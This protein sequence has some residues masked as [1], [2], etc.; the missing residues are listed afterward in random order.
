MAKFHPYLPPLRRRIISRFLIIVG[1]YAIFGIVMI[2][3]VFFASRMTPRLIHV[4]YD[5]IAAANQMNESWFNINSPQTDP[6]GNLDLWQAN[7]ETALNIEEHNI[8]EPGEGDVAKNIRTLWD[9]SKS[10]LTSI[11]QGDFLKMKNLLHRL[12]SI[13]E[14]GMFRIA[15]DSA[16]LSH[17]VFMGGIV[18]LVV[19]LIFVFFVSNGIANRLAYPLKAMAETLRSRPALGTKLKLPNPT[20]LELKILNHEMMQLWNNLSDLRQLNVEEINVQRNQLR[21]ILTF[22]EDA[23]LVLNIDGTVLHANPGL[24]KYLNLPLE[25]IIGRQWNDLSTSNENYLHLRAVLQSDLGQHHATQIVVNGQNRSLSIRFREIENEKKQVT[26]ILYLLHDV[27]ERRQTEKLRRE[28]I[29]VLSHEL[30]TPLQSLSVCSQLLNEH[31]GVLS[32]DGQ[33]LV[34]TINEDV[35]RIRAVANDFIQVGVENLSSLKLM[36]EQVHLEDVIPQWLKPFKVLAKDKKINIEFETK[37]S[38]K[39]LAKIDQVKFPWVISNIL[40][41]SIRI[42]P[43]NTKIRV[44]LKQS[45]DEIFVEIADEGPGIPPEVQK[46]MFDPY[47]QASEPGDGKATGFLGIGLT[48]AKEVVEAHNGSIKFTPNVPHGA[49]FTV[50]LPRIHL[51]G[52]LA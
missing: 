41:N 3:A 24:Q 9:S 8:T 11:P 43:P 35:S 19:T 44:I 16:T 17:E 4:N 48:I 32:N 1:L 27:T 22:V 31:K 26:G 33:L 23:I 39:S 28:F 2:A 7:F 36:L 20:S 45:N 15:E 13:N 37:A 34:D 49:I 51:A 18:F 21:T 29:G 50:S 5:S 40:A 6:R 47:Y 12:V 38:E 14:K 30:K 10:H 25:E 52:V 42:S 46:R